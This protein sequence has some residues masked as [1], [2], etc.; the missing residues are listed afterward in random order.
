MKIT[1]RGLMKSRLFGL[2]KNAGGII[3]AILVK[4]ILFLWQLPQLILGIIVG[5][6]WYNAGVL[7][8]VKGQR[9]ILPV[10]MCLITNKCVSGVSFGPI[11]FLNSYI[12]HTDPSGLAHEYGH[13]IQS[14]YLGWL[15]LIIVGLPSIIMATLCSILEPYSR[16]SSHISRFI[17]NYYNRY[18]ENWANQLGKYCKL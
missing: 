2:M 18:P 5:L 15:Y 14:V 1:I 3:I 8:I 17:G 7:I 13:S 6:F 11:I 12:Y 16:T 4:L 10:V 9:K